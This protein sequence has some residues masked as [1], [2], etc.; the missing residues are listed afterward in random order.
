MLNI[1]KRKKKESLRDYCVKLYGEEFGKQYDVLNSGGSIG[2]YETTKAFL[3]KL[4]RAKEKKNGIN[5]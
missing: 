4:E 2:N 3:K 5:R 1:F